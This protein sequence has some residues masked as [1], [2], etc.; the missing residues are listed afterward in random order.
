MAPGR[1][2]IS[3]QSSRAGQRGQPE[4]PDTGL[5]QPIQPRFEFL[6]GIDPRRLPAHFL[7]PRFRVSQGGIRLCARSLAPRNRTTR[8]DPRLGAALAQS[9]NDRNRGRRPDR[10]PNQKPDPPFH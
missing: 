6:Q 5:A 1:P 4:R 7:D 8:T 2:H 9:Q 10:S 3:S